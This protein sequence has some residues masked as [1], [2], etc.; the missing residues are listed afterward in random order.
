[1]LED[2]C[3]RL[4]LIIDYIIDWARETYRPNILRQLNILSGEYLE[5]PLERGLGISRTN[6]LEDLV[7]SPIIT[8][9]SQPRDDVRGLSIECEKG[10]IQH[11]GEIEA[12]VR[13]VLITT[14][15]LQTL[16]MSFEEPGMSKKFAL[17]VWT[18]LFDHAMELDDDDA[19]NSIE[20]IWTVNARPINPSTSTAGKCKIYAT[21]TLAYYI[22][23]NW[24]IVREISFLAIAGDALV[25]LFAAAGRP[26]LKS[27]SGPNDMVAN[28]CALPSP[29]LRS[30]CRRQRVSPAEQLQR[31]TRRQ[32]L[33]L[34]PYLENDQELVD[35]FESENCLRTV[36][37]LF[38]RCTIG[39]REPNEPFLRSS[40]GI[41]RK[42][43][44]TVAN[45]YQNLKASKNDMVLVFG[46]CL[47]LDKSATSS[48]LLCLY[49]FRNNLELSEVIL[50]YIDALKEYKNRSSYCYTVRK[51]RFFAK[52]SLPDNNQKVIHL[53]QNEI[54]QRPDNSQFK[55]A[56]RPTMKFPAPEALVR[57][58]IKEL[59]TYL[60]N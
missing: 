19:L 58:W 50:D 49:V 54:H 41:F 7:K 10:T 40:N 18:E 56:P 12:R 34:E 31:A 20:Q 45:V 44:G 17:E 39:R 14:D 60:S 15:N 25:H 6:T 4:L 37:E 28:A 8:R 9:P 38:Q 55:L 13:G 47:N 48:P 24:E 33:R 52:A 16:L 5:R 27:D 21:I 42:M 51:G 36:H 22:G 30:L 3:L 57:I 43:A 46:D 2:D 1:M 29:L 32:I 53:H 35:W 23:L 26:R 11:A 59:E